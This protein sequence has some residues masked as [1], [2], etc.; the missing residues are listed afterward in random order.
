MSPE[1]FAQILPLIVPFG[2]VVV[3]V[4]LFMFSDFRHKG[5]QQVIAEQI[6]DKKLMR[7]QVTKY[8][9]LLRENYVM[10]TRVLV[11]LERIEKKLNA[12]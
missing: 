7:E 9:A 5:N 1:L 3:V 2:P 11:V 4:V 8:E 12:V 6:E 10:S